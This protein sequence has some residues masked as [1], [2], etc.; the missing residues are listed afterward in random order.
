MFE[1]LCAFIVLY[2]LI[3]WVWPDPRV[4]QREDDRRHAEMLAAI[5]SVARQHSAPV[6]TS[7]PQYDAAYR[8]RVIALGRER[9]RENSLKRHPILDSAY[10]NLA[11]IPHNQ[12]VALVILQSGLVGKMPYT[13]YTNGSIEA[14]LPQGTLR[15][16]S[17]AELRSYL[18]KN[19]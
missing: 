14:Q 7:A 4:K 1:S 18:E 3:S 10:A 12:P 11:S 5:A 15:F 9:D 8:A 17:L 16:G 2:V 6:A 19:A 13:L